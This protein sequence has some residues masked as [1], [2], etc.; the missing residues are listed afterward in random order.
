MLIG[1]ARTSTV[2]QQAG[3]DAQLKELE[4]VGCEKVFSEQVS[5]L[6]KRPQ[7][8]A[9]LDFCREGDVF[10]V[11]KLDRLARS[12]TDLGRIV[13]RLE[14][15]KVTLRILNINLDTGS[16]TGR[17]MLN[18]LG[19]VAQ[20]EV[21]IMR[22]RQREGIAKAQAEGRYRGRK[23]TARAK[24][25]EAKKLLQSGMTPSAVARQLSISRASV[26]RIMDAA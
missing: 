18:L 22:E 12:V 19:S 21:E 26:Y 2:D 25:G 1:Y 10:V 17:L 7:L 6:G 8:D 20:F 4:A 5:S 23:P 14:A 16:P 11:T 3:F 9:A 15:K 24:A 13:E